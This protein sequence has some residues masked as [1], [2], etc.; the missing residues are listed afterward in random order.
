MNI[1]EIPSLEFEAAVP[2][3]MKHTPVI[4]GQIVVGVIIGVVISTND[5]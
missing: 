3:S 4:L 2:G 5:P 1:N